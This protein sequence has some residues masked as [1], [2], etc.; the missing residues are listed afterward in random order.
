MPR[1]ITDYILYRWR[2]VIGYLIV[3]LLV[4]ALLVMAV[5]YV[6]GGLSEA[7]MASAVSSDQLLLGDF[8]PSAIID[9]PYRLLQSV[10]FWL[11]GVSTLSV[12]LPSLIIGMFSVAGTILLLRQWLHGNVAVIA[13]LIII[14]TSQ[15]IFASQDG[16]PTIMYIFMSTWLLYLALKVSRQTGKHSF[17]EFALVA[18][19]A[20]SLYTPLS[21]YIILALVS[22]TMLHPHLR[23]IV[24]RLS[25]RKLMAA[26]L[27]GLLLLAPLILALTIKPEVGLT[28]LGIPS[29][30]PNLK[31]NGIELLQS[32]FDFSATSTGNQFRPIY[33]LP[34]LLLAA[35]GVV[36][37]FATRHTARSY[38][39]TSW[40]ILLTPI[41]LINPNKTII[42][43]MP[44]M[45]LMAAGIDILLYRWYRLFPR[46]PYARVAGLLPVTLLMLGMALTGLE[47]Y[48]YVYRYNPEVVANFSS[49]LTLI[50]QQLD[51]TE[52]ESAALLTTEA[53]LPFYKVF[54][55]Q[56]SRVQI[57][58]SNQPAPPD[59]PIIA[60]REAY[61]ERD[62]GTPNRIITNGRSTHSDRLYLYKTDKE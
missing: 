33:T 29:S 61:R 12:K 10:S 32:Y 3:G 57:V 39:I 13:A 11:F 15:F 38:I 37:L 41:I 53:E 26:G 49:D 50:Q 24:S 36:R 23:F 28:L 8:E 21:I 35:V 14:T 47:R 2:Y 25:R 19:V 22:A 1:Q 59:T 42:T 58:M 18:M 6:P 56:N 60:T 17:W 5:I 54:A 31:A 44:F 27:L 20:I 7:E 45:L 40:M 62:L 30:M 34:S 48:F 4:S 55:A 52:S 43:F 9:L 51:N 46:N 16:T